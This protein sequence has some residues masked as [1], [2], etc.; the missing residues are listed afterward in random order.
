MT[1]IRVHQTVGGFIP[2]LIPPAP[3]T[4]AAWPVWHDSTTQDVKFFPQSK[5]DILRRWRKLQ[6]WNAQTK[7]RGC[8]GG[9]IGLTAMTVAQCLIFQFPRS[10]CGSLPT[11]TWGHCTKVL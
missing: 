2:N 5:K 4:Y 7:Q 6:Q 10:D 9:G 11:P 8:H 3:K 1:F